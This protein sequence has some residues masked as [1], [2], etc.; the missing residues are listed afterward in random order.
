MRNS[1]RPLAS[2]VDVVA[3]PVRP[4]TLDAVDLDLLRLLAGD[5]RMSQR[6]LARDLGMSPPAVGERVARLER[7]GVIRG[8]TV[9]IGWAEAGFPVTVFLTIT[10]VQG[11]SL[12][13]II[14]R[15]RELPEVAEVSL[16]TGAIDLLA[17]LV[18]RDHNH[19]QKLLLERV[20]QITGVQRTET[21]V[22][23]AEMQPKPFAAQLISSMRTGLHEARGH[24]GG[25]G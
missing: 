11:H 20:W 22:T 18:V 1:A 2:L 6:R 21:L 19:L 9:E 16:V 3:R 12:A 8:Y 13:P 7:S 5:A 14:E 24:Q 10:A 15:L 4:A 17:R 23:L 25:T